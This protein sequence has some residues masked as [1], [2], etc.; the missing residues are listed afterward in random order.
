MPGVSVVALDF[1]FISLMIWYITPAI[2]HTK[3]I[4]KPIWITGA[5]GLAA[6]GALMGRR[7]NVSTTAGMQEKNSVSDRIKTCMYSAPFP[8]GF[9]DFAKIPKGSRTNMIRARKCPGVGCPVF[10]IG[11]PVKQ[12]IIV[13]KTYT[14]PAPLAGFMRP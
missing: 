13:S 6:I 14:L 11:S 9:M 8:N 10:I 5:L 2:K 7:V 3:S 12:V 4:I 1:V